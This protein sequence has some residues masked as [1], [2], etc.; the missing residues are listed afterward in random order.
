MSQLRMNA[1]RSIVVLIDYQE[2]LMPAIHEGERVTS[3]A[4]FVA[5][6]ANELGVP[7]VATEQAPDKLGHNVAAIAGLAEVVIDKD[8][9]GACEGGLMPLLPEDAEVVIAGCEAHVCLIQTALGLLEAGRRVWVI[10]DASGSRRTSD[11]E[12]AMARVAAAG[13]TVVTS[14]MVA[15]EWLGSH[16]HPNFRAVS[17]LVKVTD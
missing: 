5:Q 8:T 6:V 4:A 3:R 7:V 15:F 13:A 11:H 2:K 17:K 12:A 14:E 10:S 9:F 16:Q 1:E